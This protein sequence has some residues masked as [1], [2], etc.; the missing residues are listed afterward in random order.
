MA[1][2]NAMAGLR[3]Q[4]QV[5][6]QT[7][8]HLKQEVAAEPPSRPQNLNP[9]A[10]TVV[11]SRR[12]KRDTLAADDDD[13][14]SPKGRKRIKRVASW[15]GTASSATGRHDDHP[16]VLSSPLPLS[17]E[18]PRP[19]PSPATPFQ[20][21]LSECLS[22]CAQQQWRRRNGWLWQE[23]VTPDG[24]PTRAYRRHQTIKDMVYTVA[25][26]NWASATERPTTIRDV[27]DFL[28]V[29]TAADSRLPELVMQRTLTAW[30]NGLFDAQTGVLHSYA[31]LAACSL[32][33]TALACKYFAV[34][35][36]TS[37]LIL[38]DKDN[39]EG[40]YTPLDELLHSQ[41]HD[42]RERTFVQA[43]LGRLVFGPNELDD[44]RVLL[45]LYGPP[46]DAVAAILSVCRH[47]FE[48][49]DVHTTRLDD[50]H[51][52]LVEPTGNAG[53]KLFT[54][55]DMGRQSTLA[56]ATVR[57]M[58]GASDGGSIKWSGASVVLAGSAV[59][60]SWRSS[61]DIDSVQRHVVLIHFPRPHGGG[62]RHNNRD[63]TDRIVAAF[64]SVYRQC[65]MAYTRLVR[66]HGRQSSVHKEMMP[67]RFL[68]AQ[69]HALFLA[70]DS[71]VHFVQSDHWHIGSTAR[72]VRL[73][74]LLAAYRAYCSSWR[75]QPRLVQQTDLERILWA[76]GAAGIVTE[77]RPW[78]LGAS[79]D[80]AG[81]W[82]DR[83]G[84][85]TSG[86]F[87]VGIEERRTADCDDGG[88]SIDH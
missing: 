62:S 38:V 87:C 88:A 56:P 82:D 21:L 49:D 66:Q 72:H 59:P 25:D 41:G 35:F 29:C 32:P 9:G 78:P 73:D 74:T 69:R 43:M 37:D 14:V 28:H 18:A 36:D 1:T 80:R 34:P 46:G 79:K 19:R 15:P 17:S 48:D 40:L 65:I 4:I 50:A 75:F 31:D 10:Q 8:D 63:W 33:L 55:T 6:A 5:L 22:L 77:R 42:R 67:T 85:L 7:V 60:D 2:T 71:L 13:V 54:V 44:W 83:D 70:P 53:A 11:V 81:H 47:L 57:R 27:I 24:Q 51:S 86:T 39:H 20:T 76:A 23:I 84:P 26:A 61:D 58:A 30:T 52:G 16:S 45:M 68:K 3:H 12:R 64:G